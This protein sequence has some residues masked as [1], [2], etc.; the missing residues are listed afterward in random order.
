ML[1]LERRELVV[2]N[3]RNCLKA[4]AAAIPAAAGSAVAAAAPIQLHCDL[5]VDPKREKEMLANFAKVFRPTIRKQPGFVDVKLLKLRSEIQGKAPANS[6]YR[7]IISFQT[8]EQRLTWVAT[9]DHQRAWPTVENTLVGM[10][11][12]AL[13]YDPVA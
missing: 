9:D 3:R 7:L 6:T 13:L 10:K 8:E 1:G 2:M 5:F 12:Q 4:I 11:Y